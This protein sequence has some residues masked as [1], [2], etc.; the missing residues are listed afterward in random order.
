MITFK[1]ILKEYDQQHRSEEIENNFENDVLIK[2]MTNNDPD[3][4]E[5]RELL[6]RRSDNDAKKLF[7][8]P[9]KFERK[10]VVIG[11]FHNII[12]N[13]SKY[14]KDYPKRT[15]SV[16]FT[17]QHGI[18]EWNGGTLYQ[19]IPMNNAKIA[20]SSE[21][22]FAKSFKIGLGILSKVFEYKFSWLGD[23]NHYVEGFLPSEMRYKTNINSEEIKNIINN[24]KEINDNLKLKNMLKKYD[25]STLYDLID[26]CLSPELN[27]FR[28]VN[29]NDAFKDI[30]SGQ[31]MYTD[32]NC[33][34]L[35]AT[36]D[37]IE[38]IFE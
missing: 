22:D 28:L 23:L 29:Y 6:L 10:S 37:I 16:V 34:L 20:I 11:Y 2:K 5:S 9:S 33:L 13:N 4:V 25:C 26:Y 21:T 35:E 1:N 38:K 27:G 12:I 7:I 30:T 32:E 36:T 3:K 8:Q 31:E 17:D 18:F 19:V 24:I 14:W 15:K